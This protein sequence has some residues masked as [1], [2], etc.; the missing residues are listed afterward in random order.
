LYA[1][2]KAWSRAFWRSVPTGEEGIEPHAEAGS[3]VGAG[4]S[5]AIARRVPAT[6]V[7]TRNN[8]ISAGV[9]VAL[10]VGLTV[11]AG[12]LYGFADQAAADL[13]DN[14]L[15]IRSVLPEGVR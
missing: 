10:G 6:G 3:A 15:Y 7:H 4:G 13:F 12:P 1:M 5:I 11:V 14:M 8:I 9:L 2:A